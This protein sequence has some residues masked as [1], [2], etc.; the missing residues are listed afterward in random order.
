MS[1]LD[2][3]ILTEKNKELVIFQKTIIVNK[4]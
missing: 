4:L 3:N 2:F 1:L